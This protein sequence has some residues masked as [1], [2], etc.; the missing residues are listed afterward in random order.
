MET[1]AV[2]KLNYGF[3]FLLH[4]YTV[5]FRVLKPTLLHTLVFY[6]MVLGSI[7]PC[8]QIPGVRKN[9]SSAI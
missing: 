4:L 9:N 5:F 8:P 6:Q 1:A 2:S 3:Q 7:P